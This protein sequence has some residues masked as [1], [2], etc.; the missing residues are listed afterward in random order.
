MANAYE[1]SL[2]NQAPALT[3]ETIAE[4]RGLIGVPLRR[5]RNN[6]VCTLP[7]ITAWVQGIGD[8]NP[9]YRDEGVG[10]RS[11]YGCVIAPPSWMYSVDLTD[12]APKLRG[13]HTIYAGAEWEWYRMVRVG[14]EISVSAK[15]IEVKEKEGRFCGKMILQTGE[16]TYANQRGEIVARCLP[17]ILRAPRAKAKARGKYLGISTYHYT[18]QELKAIYDSYEAEKIRGAEIR[19]WEDINVGDEIT[20]VVKGPL[21]VVDTL[22]FCN[23]ANV[24]ALAFERWLAHRRRHPADVYLNP[25]TGLLDSPAA[26]LFEDGMAREFGFPS[27]HDTGVQ[28][29]AWLV[30]LLTHWMGDD[31][32]LKKMDVDILLPNILGDT[33]WCKG[34]VMEK[35]VANGEHLVECHIRAENQRGEVTAKGNVVIALISKELK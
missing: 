14:D 4:V 9:L 35:R 6:E 32:F 23:G 18:E 3:E 30:T 29:V 10:R 19:Y 2:E 24:P 15:L 28:R 11:R 25:Q 27:A 31:A 16:V 17:R 20:P 21:S 7:A 5:T 13:I 12:V 26:S 22:F 8:I 33:T 34:R 1:W